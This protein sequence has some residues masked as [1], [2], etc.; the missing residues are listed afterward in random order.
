MLA[1]VNK[2]AKAIW[3]R[4]QANGKTADQT[5]AAVPLVAAFLRRTVYPYT[6]GQPLTPEAFDDR[7]AA[8]AEDEKSRR[9]QIAELTAEPKSAEP[10]PKRLTPAESAARMR[11]LDAAR[12]NGGTP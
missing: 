9:R 5:V 6:E 8:A 4:Q 7:W 1:R 3:S 11:E 10:K 2:A 12:R